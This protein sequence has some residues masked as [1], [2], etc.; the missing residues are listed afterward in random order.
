[1]GN[2]LVSGQ[3]YKEFTLY[4]CNCLYYDCRV[5]IYKHKLLYKIGHRYDSRVVIYD[6]IAVIRLATGSNIVQKISSIKLEAISYKNL[7]STL[8]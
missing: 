1:M 7:Y 5:V 2:F 4:D 3:F 6:R 8:K